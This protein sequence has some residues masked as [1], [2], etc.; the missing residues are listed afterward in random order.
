M[1]TIVWLNQSEKIRL[2]SC[3]RS[4]ASCKFL[5][6]VLSCFSCFCVV[7]KCLPFD[8]TASFPHSKISVKYLWT[9]IPFFKICYFLTYCTFNKLSNI[10]SNS[11][12]HSPLPG[13]NSAI[14]NGHFIKKKVFSYLNISISFNSLLSWSKSTLFPIGWSS[15]VIKLSKY[16]L[17][18]CKASDEWVS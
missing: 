4:T 1:H 6:D 13:V 3:K 15:V 5:I 2:F 7:F 17:A 12:V 11:L 8:V 16:I 10:T 18:V 14:T 9:S